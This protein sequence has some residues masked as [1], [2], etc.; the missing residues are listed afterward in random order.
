MKLREFAKESKKTFDG[1]KKNIPIVGLE[2]L[3]SN[4]LLFSNYDLNTENT[5]S[6]CFTKGQVLFGRRRAYLKK[7]AFAEI[8]GINCGL[9]IA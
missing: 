8:D 3:N 9:H 7:A 5:F 4:E 6:K 1:D 2:H